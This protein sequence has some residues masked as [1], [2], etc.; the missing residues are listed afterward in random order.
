V[1]EVEPPFTQVDRHACRRSCDRPASGDLGRPARSED[2]DTSGSPEPGV[3][4]RSRPSRA[5]PMMCF[6]TAR[7]HRGTNVA[8]RHAV[9]HPEQHRRRILR[10][11]LTIIEPGQTASAM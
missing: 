7:E 10:T 3:P 11:A 6:R 5:F 2:N 8:H 1:T 4:A 9:V